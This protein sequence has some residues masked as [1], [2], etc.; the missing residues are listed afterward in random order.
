MPSYCFCT[1]HVTG[2]NVQRFYCGLNASWQHQVINNSLLRVYNW[3]NLINC[4]N[5]W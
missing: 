2:E 4:M 5:E 1:V 3:H